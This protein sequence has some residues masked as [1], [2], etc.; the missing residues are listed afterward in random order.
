[1]ELER[2]QQQ[3]QS[4]PCFSSTRQRTI[5]LH[6][7]NQTSSWETT[8]WSTSNRP[9]LLLMSSMD[10]ATLQCSAIISNFFFFI[11]SK[12]F[13]PAKHVPAHTSYLSFEAKIFEVGTIFVHSRFNFLLGD[14]FQTLKALVWPALILDHYILQNFLNIVMHDTPM[15]T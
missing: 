4:N 5:S 1:M 14:R 11:I 9:P 8:H 7:D 3:W 12:C 2:K 6:G 10:G 15:A 13:S